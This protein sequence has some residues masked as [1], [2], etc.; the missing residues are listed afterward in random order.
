MDATAQL[1]I[2]EA[3]TRPVL[4][5]EPRRGPDALDLPPRF[6]LPALFAGLR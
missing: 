3:S 5:R 4:D 6:Q 1:A 2:D